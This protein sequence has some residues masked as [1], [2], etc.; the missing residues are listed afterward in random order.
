MTD[1]EFG[2]YAQMQLVHCKNVRNALNAKANDIEAMARNGLSADT[3]T[4][5]IAAHDALIT[6]LYDSIPTEQDAIDAVADV[7]NP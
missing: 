7:D 2:Q 6:G 1:E 4:E 5:V 3:T